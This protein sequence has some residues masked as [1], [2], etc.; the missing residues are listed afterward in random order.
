MF[1]LGATRRDDIWLCNKYIPPPTLHHCPM[2]YIV[3]EN[4]VHYPLTLN[5]QRHKSINYCRFCT[6]YFFFCKT[7]WERSIEW[8][9]GLLC[10]RRYLPPTSTC[11][12]KGGGTECPGSRL[13]RVV[14]SAIFIIFFFLICSGRVVDEMHA[15]KW[16][17]DKLLYIF[18][19]G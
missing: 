6:I 15:F 13:H 11:R 16:K 17:P 1:S 18:S 4:V 19:F 2:E 10:Y 7:I 8:A 14:F 5:V 3:I 12:D 9:D